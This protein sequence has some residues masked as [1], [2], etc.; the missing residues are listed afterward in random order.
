MLLISFSVPPK[1]PSY[2]Q[3][4]ASANFV[5]LNGLR[6]GSDY[7]V[8]VQQLSAMQYA[9]K[10]VLAQSVS[11]VDITFSLADALIADVNDQQIVLQSTAYSYGLYLKPS[12]EE[13]ADSQL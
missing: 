12:T 9:L 13:S 8:V 7:T 3:Q 1:S 2:I 10:I 5:Q 6:A 4:L 11:K